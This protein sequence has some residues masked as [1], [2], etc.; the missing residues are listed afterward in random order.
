MP[1][2]FTPKYNLVDPLSP[3]MN[4]RVPLFDFTDPPVDPVELAKDM[5]NHIL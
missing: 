5:I 1:S 3:I 4:T 2:N